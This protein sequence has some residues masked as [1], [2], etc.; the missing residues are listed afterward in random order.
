MA[1]ATENSGLPSGYDEA[2]VNPIDEDFNCTICQLPL[3][4]PTITRCGHRFCKECIDEHLQRL[5]LN[6]EQFLVLI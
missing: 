5:V 3:M 6:E 1:E 4:E 2:F